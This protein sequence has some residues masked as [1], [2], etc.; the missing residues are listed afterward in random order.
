MANDGLRIQ[1]AWA[2]PEAD[3]AKRR[4]VV[5]FAAESLHKQVEDLGREGIALRRTGFVG[6]LGRESTVYPDSGASQCVER[7]QRSDVVVRDAHP[8][9]DRVNERV[10]RGVKRFAEVDKEQI[11]VVLLPPALPN[12][13]KQ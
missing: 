1:Y 12:A 13:L 9:Q 3:S 8:P 6:Y 4:R 2:A 11:Y 7:F 5:E 10:V